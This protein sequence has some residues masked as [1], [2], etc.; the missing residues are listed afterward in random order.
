M[1]G[2]VLGYG[3][4]GQSQGGETGEDEGLERRRVW[5]VFMIAVS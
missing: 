3:R 5:A 4:A 1:R 2:D